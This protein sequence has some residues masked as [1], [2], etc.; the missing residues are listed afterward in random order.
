M[1]Y[2]KFNPTRENCIVR[3]VADH[4][5]EKTY[6]VCVGKKNYYEYIAKSI[7]YVEDGNI[8]APVWATYFIPLK[9]KKTNK[10]RLIYNYPNG[11]EVKKGDFIRFA[12]DNYV[13]FGRTYE[14]YDWEDDN[15]IGLGTDATNPK[16]IADG[17]AYPCEGGIYPFEISDKFVK[18]DEE[19]K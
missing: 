2:S 15:T 6:A 9:K 7:C 18:A 14:V 10:T 4:E 5:T 11:E 3:I 12:D 8:Y 17:R 16:L 13:P 1:N 19:E